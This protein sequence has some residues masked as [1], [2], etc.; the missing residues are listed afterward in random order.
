M[1]KNESLGYIVYLAMLAVAVII[2]LTVVR[3]DFLSDAAR[4]LSMHPAVITILS[5]VVGVV[6]TAL[7]LELGHLLGAKAGHYKVDKFVILGLGF[8]TKKSG[9]KHLVLKDFDG[10]TGETAVVP[11]DIKKSN[12]RPIIWL[13][14]LFLFLEI[15]ASVIVIVL[16]STDGSR[17]WLKI[18]GEIILTIACM[19]LLYD[20]F[21]AA[22]DSKNDGYLLL[23]LNNKTN[24]EAYNSMLYANHLVSRGEPAPEI[25]VYD[26]V[27]D[28][29]ASVND[30]TL[31]K[32]L[33]EHDYDKA[34]EVVEKTLAC[35]KKVSAGVYND[36]VCQ[37]LSII[38]LTKPFEEAKEY[39]INL[40]LEDKKRMSALNS[41]PAIRAY[42]LANGIIEESE[43]ETKT[44]L[45]RVNAKL[46]KVSKER[47]QTE[48]KLLL[49]AV[50][51][52]HEKNPDWDFSEYAFWQEAH[53]EEAKQEEEET[54]N[55]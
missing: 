38:I 28:F 3:P 47:K 34:S 48:K 54:P 22:L 17:L 42:L 26:D 37:M 23:I 8:I 14:L 52:V 46:R 11:N 2:G 30:V 6:L 4:D 16:G 53:P 15:V 51:R 39:F 19:V 7:M 36:A 29:T 49:E 1:K 35:K 44:A 12:P 43:S 25:T 13:G 10:L 50:E 5:I 32:H 40:P 21:P 41:M 45:D 24:Q 9:K 31:Y 55:E 18:A 20:I 27:T 33:D